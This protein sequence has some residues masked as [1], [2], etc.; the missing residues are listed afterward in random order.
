MLTDV[1]QDY[2]EAGAD[3]IETNTFSGTSI[4]Q[5]D[6][7]LEYLVRRLNKQSAILAKKA[8][9]DVTNE[10]GLLIIIYI[11]LIF[12]L[13]LLLLGIKRYVAGSVGPTNKTLSVS[14]SVEKP[15]FRN[16]SMAAKL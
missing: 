6:Y 16:I 9:I 4:A 14:P 11:E 13:I 12:F 7:G 3:F 5:A 2:L 8:A 15:E 1:A 10:T